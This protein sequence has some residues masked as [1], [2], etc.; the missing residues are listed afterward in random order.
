MDHKQKSWSLPDE[1][2]K[3]GSVIYDEGDSLTEII[4]D[5]EDHEKD[6][7]EEEDEDGSQILTRQAIEESQQKPAE[8]RELESTLHNEENSENLYEHQAKDSAQLALKGNLDLKVTEGSEKQTEQEGV[9]DMSKSTE[10]EDTLTEDRNLYKKEEVSSSDLNQ[11]I[12]MDVPRSDLEE[13]AKSSTPDEQTPEDTNPIMTQ[14]GN[15]LLEVSST[16]I[17]NASDSESL[18]VGI[19]TVIME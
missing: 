15:Y 13:L 17:S 19:Q 14:N 2:V 5:I 4:D 11:E 12:D 3:E 6:E 16:H 10:T 1:S 8:M 9:T 18:E 7:D